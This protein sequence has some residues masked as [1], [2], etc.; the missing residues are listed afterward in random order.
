M[1]FQQEER[2][3]EGVEGRGQN[4]FFFNDAG[5]SFD[6]LGHSVGKKYL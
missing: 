3:M 6:V 5:F 2:G 4:R 1:A